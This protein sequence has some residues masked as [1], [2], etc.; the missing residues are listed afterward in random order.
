MRVPSTGRRWNYSIGFD[1]CLKFGNY[2]DMSVFKRN[3]K[4][5]DLEKED[6]SGESSKDVESCSS[7][8]D[9]A[10]G[11]NHS[12]RPLDESN[13]YKDLYMRSMADFQN[14]KRRVEKERSMWVRDANADVIKRF[15]SVVDDIDRAVKSC[16]DAG[17]TNLQVDL[18]HS[19]LAGLEL[20]QKNLKKAFGDFKVAEIDCS[21]QFSPDLHEA[22]IEV[23]SPDHTSGEIVD[24]M[25]KGYVM[26]IGSSDVEDDY[27]VLRHAKVSVAK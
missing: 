22:L 5:K 9:S 20:V 18:I 17:K 19:I 15:L 16:Q 12:T 8:D 27:F 1:P 4:K 7:N 25:N 24:V 11:C 14:Y 13:E 2:V 10:C 26:T 6:V 3:K 21:G 23:D